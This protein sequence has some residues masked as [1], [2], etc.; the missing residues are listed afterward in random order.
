V[1]AKLPS[2]GKG[3]AY[4]PKKIKLSQSRSLYARFEQL[5]CAYGTLLV[6][7]P[8]IG[9][10]SCYR[11]EVGK[12]PGNDPKTDDWLQFEQSGNLDPLADGAKFGIRG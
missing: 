11:P 6:P 8:I 10:S 1:E 3:T 5:N 4:R 9:A 12:R 2:T 7:N